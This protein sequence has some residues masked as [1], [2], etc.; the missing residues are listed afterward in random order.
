MSK[1]YF[2]VME[3]HRALPR[4]RH[5][6]LKLMKI[7]RTIQMLNS[8]SIEYDDEHNSLIND[9]RVNK[10]FHRLYYK[11]YKEIESIVEVGGVV[12]DIEFGIVDFY[13]MHEGREIVLCW[14]LGEKRIKFWHEAGEGYSSR[15]PVSIL[16]RNEF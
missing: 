5:S 9:I 11:L 16:L 2:T 6:L 7:N 3:A 15:K 12:K 14:R 10:T 4:I 1:K 13:S 8:V